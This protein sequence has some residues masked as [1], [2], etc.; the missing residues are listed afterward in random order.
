[1][2]AERTTC[3]PTA[4]GL[5]TALVACLLLTAGTATAYVLG[6]F[7]WDGGTV[8]GWDRDHQTW[9]ALTA[10]AGGGSSGGYLR[11]EFPALGGSSP[12][13]DWYDLVSV[14][15]SHLFAGDWDQNMTVEFDFFAENVAP[16]GLEVRMGVNDGRTW[17]YDLD[18]S[19]VTVGEWGSFDAPLASWEDW[20]LEPFLSEGDYLADLENIDWIGVYIFRDGTGAENYG[21]DDFRLTIPEPHEYAM[22]S[23]T[24]FVIAISLRRRTT[25]QHV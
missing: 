1:M 11:I 20:A 8:Q 6:G 23:V 4:A 3:R 19:S 16:A 25:P 2:R 15:S 9:P 13:E 12:G 21:L 5:L 18:T 17:G 10:P 24:L 22:L 14:P 7:D